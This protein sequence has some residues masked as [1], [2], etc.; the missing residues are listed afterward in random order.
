VSRRDPLVVAALASGGLG[1]LLLF[2]FDAWFTRALGVLGLFGFIAAGVFA[3]ATPAF[4]ERDD[5]ED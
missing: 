1:A 3:I 4:L 5:S 2:A